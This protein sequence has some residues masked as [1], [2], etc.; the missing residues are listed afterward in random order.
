MHVFCYQDNR[1]ALVTL[2]P[3]GQQVFQQMMIFSR[4][5]EAHLV[6]GLGEEEQ[7]GIRQTLIHI[8]EKFSRMKELGD[9]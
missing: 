4:E 2:M 7:A 5:F 6:A 8:Q 3:M 9:E 1:F